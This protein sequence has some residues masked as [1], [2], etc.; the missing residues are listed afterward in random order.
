MYACVSMGLSVINDI[1]YMLVFIF[2]CLCMHVLVWDDTKNFKAPWENWNV[3]KTSKFVIFTR[4][5]PITK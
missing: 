3:H 4:R 2:V 5:Q 1:I